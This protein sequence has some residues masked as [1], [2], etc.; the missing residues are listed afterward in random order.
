[1]S[2]PASTAP[3]LE[4]ERL[5]LVPLTA[6]DAPNIFSL[7]RDAEVMAFWDVPEIDDPDVIAAIV[8]GQVEEMTRGAAAYWALRTLADGQFVGV[9]DL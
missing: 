3:I 1:M 7:M 2:P 6:A 4:T 8:A 5:R 9:C